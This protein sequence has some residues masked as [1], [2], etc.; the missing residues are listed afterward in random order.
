MGTHLAMTDRNPERRERRLARSPKGVAV[1][2]EMLD[3]GATTE[4]SRLDEAAT[5]V[6]V[7]AS[8]LG[9]STA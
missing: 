5:A 7:Q 2:V 4:R 9:L 8:A 6:R 1:D 3:L